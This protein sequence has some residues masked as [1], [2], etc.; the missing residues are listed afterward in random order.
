[1]GN[2]VQE[3]KLEPFLAPFLFCTI[4]NVKSNEV[5]HQ[6]ITTALNE[7]TQISGGAVPGAKLRQ[8]INR[9]AA[10]HGE[11]YP[12][13]GDE[14]KKFTEFLNQ[15]S[16]LL[17]VL[18][19]TGQDILVAPADKPQLL[20]LSQNA[21]TELREDIFEAFTRIPSHQ[22]PWYERGTD[23]ISWA[24]AEETLDSDQFV[25]IPPASLEQEIGD[26]KAFASS[27]EIDPEVKDNLL[28]TLQEHSALWAF[29]K[30]IKKYGLSRRWHLFRLQGIVKRIRQWCESQHVEWRAEWLST[31]ADGTAK[32]QTMKRAASIGGES[33]LLGKL[34]ESLNE[35]E[36][37]RV[38]LPLDIILKLLQK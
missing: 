17:I 27:P 22:S 34:I 3:E 4:S 23:R 21:S 5:W 13:R 30:A 1:M 12:P 35:E 33:H 18:K 6:I 28:A 36:L 8:L 32:V 15:F 31:R 9:I 19:R 26:R 7:G 10:K 11:Q 20:D 37:K 38:S 16:S 2:R 14:D 25:K 24:A 29:S